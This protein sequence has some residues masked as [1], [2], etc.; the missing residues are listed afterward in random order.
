MK[1]TVIRLLLAAILIVPTVVAIVNS[2]H[3]RYAPSNERDVTRIVIEDTTGASVTYDR[4][5]TGER[6]DEVIAFFFRL[7]SRKTPIVAVPDTVLQE[8]PYLVTFFTKVKKEEYRYY[9]S[10]DPNYCYLFG[11]DGESYQLG[12]DDAAE[13]LSSDLSRCY[14][15]NSSLPTLMLSGEYKVAPKEASW[16]YK[17]FRGESI[18]SDTSGVVSTAAQ[19]FTE[20]VIFSLT[21]DTEP[22][23]FGIRITNGS[24]EVVFD[25]QK[26]NLGSFDLDSQQNVYVEVTSKWYEDAS[27]AYS[28]EA[29]YSF[30]AQVSPAPFFR[31]SADSTAKGGFLTASAK[32][33]P[34]TASVTFTSE[35]DITFDISKPFEP[36]FYRDGDRLHAIIP[37]H[38][39]LEAGEYKLT[40]TC[41]GVSQ[42]MTVNVTDPYYP[43]SSMN[44][45]DEKA[46]ECMS[47]S[48]KRE[49]ES[50]V[51]EMAAPVS[52]DRLYDGYFLS[53]GE[54]YTSWVIRDFG[55]RVLV[56]GGDK[57]VFLNNGVDV[58]YGWAADVSAVNAG[59][60]VYVGE[61]AFSGRTVVVDH[62]R[63]VKSWYW[64]LSD[65]SVAKGD[66]VT[67]GGT[68]GHAGSTGL[69]DMVYGG[70]HMAL[71][72]DGCFVDPKPT[73]SS[74][75]TF[76]EIG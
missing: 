53:G 24:G 57:Y 47:D 65:T 74:G 54:N 52:T 39:G 60:V 49:F 5:E 17:N 73:W 33:I 12:P 46:S 11:P 27:R 31:L 70:V 37:M 22:D 18:T 61:T 62:G 23:Y 25:D 29:V 36:K 13:F 44:V 15:E 55:S 19:N 10:M 51:S 58:Q 14:Y 20:N 63:G 26:A 40:F 38:A 50:L 43:D 69:T 45:T 1:K 6:S 59:T 32:N 30:S 34:E 16:T 71:S 41:S 68:V 28:G 3:V 4:D 21:Y 9:F 42:T 72:V 76:P 35:P 2:N 56:N 67:K 7:N 66:T 75:I 64:N 8:K 48:A